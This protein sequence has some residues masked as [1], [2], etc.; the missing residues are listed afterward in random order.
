V[1]QKRED[2]LLAYKHKEFF[3][4]IF[5]INFFELVGGVT[6]TDLFCFCKWGFLEFF[7]SHFQ[8]NNERDSF[9]ISGSKNHFFLKK[10]YNKIYF[11]GS[12]PI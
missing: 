4:L 10:R 1:R 2:A 7:E 12:S 8:I 6:I 5:E 3:G 9:R 11:F